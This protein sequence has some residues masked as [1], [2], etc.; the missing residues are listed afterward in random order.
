MLVRRLRYWLR[1]ATRQR[2]FRE[3][4]KLHITEIAAELEEQ[5]WS[6]SDARV[7]ARR[8]F[9]PPARVAEEV[10]EV[11]VIEW[12]EHLKQDVSYAVRTFSKSPG[13]TAVAV[14]TLALGIGVNTAIFS[15]VNAVLL[16]PLPHPQ[17]DRLMVLQAEFP[18]LGLNAL[19][20]PEYLDFRQQNRSFEAVGAYTT[21][22]GAYT[23]R[24][25]NIAAGERPLR[26][27]SI[28]VDAQLLET[29]GMPPLEG[30]FFSDE[31]TTLGI[32]RGLAAP[33]AV[34]SNEFWQAA[35]QEE[36]V[37]GNKVHIG[38]RPHEIIGVMPPGVDVGDNRT[39]VWLPLGMVCPL[40][41]SRTFHVLRVVGRL[42]PGV[43][44]DS[45][46]SELDAFLADWSARM[47]A[48]GHVPTNHPSL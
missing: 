48:A 12:L 10:R 25:V 47:E 16:E 28:S 3:E 46:R 27:R 45:A 33:V 41:Q 34:L 44:V 31:E 42:R 4:M 9:G 6:R 15:V 30:R 21:G 7:E 13:F 32:S 26:A 17:P 18:A 38:G 29:L 37:V 14:L 23:T 35:F 20:P 8:R 5:G 43:T 24:E 22:S 1:S 19:S 40:S 2:Q 39:E 36:P 11:W